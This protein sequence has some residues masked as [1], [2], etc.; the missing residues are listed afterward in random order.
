MRQII[1]D[2][3]TTGLD[4]LTGDR[5]IEV[6][7]VEL[8][9]LLPTGIGF[10]R[11]IDPERDIPAE[12]S[13]IHGFTNGDLAGK[14]KF[15]EIAAEMLDFL[16]DAPI[17]A[18]NA[19]FDFGFLDA[20]LLRAG[21]PKLNRARMIDSL[22]LAKE[23]Y[24]GMPN[25]LD[26]LCR[27]LGVDNSMRSSHNAILDCRLLAQVYLELMGGKQPGLEL[28]ASQ[29]GGGGAALATVEPVEW[30]SR[31]IAVPPARAEA[32]A[33]FVAGKV[34]D[35]LWLKPPFGGGA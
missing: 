17:V 23:R 5:I 22:M 10:H 11:L 20:E 3:E 26:A 24:P 15:A 21:L 30:T 34:K 16:G 25:S 18:H 13:R 9:N 28:A 1:L 2:T 31:P 8:V 32:H 19:P 4:P 33:A 27:R 7:A 14:P 12:A 6:A 35:A 29:G